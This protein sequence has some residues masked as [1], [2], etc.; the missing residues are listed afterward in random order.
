MTPESI[1]RELA[2]IQNRIPSALKKRVVTT[3]LNTPTVSFVVDKALEDPDFP[4]EKKR[5][6]RILKESGQFDLKRYAEDPRIGKMIDQFVQRE[7]KKKIAK[8]LLPKDPTKIA[9]IKEIYEK[10]SN[11]KQN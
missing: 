1:A 8:G 10:V 5:Q 3:T 2:D 7:I 11:N 4:E 9:G 6:L